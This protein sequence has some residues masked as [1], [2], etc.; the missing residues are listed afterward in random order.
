M[1][2]VSGSVDGD[3]DGDGDGD[4][5]GDGEEEIESGGLASRFSCSSCLL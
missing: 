4:E 3:G 5:D 2:F 1:L